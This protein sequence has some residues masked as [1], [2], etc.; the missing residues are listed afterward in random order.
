MSDACYVARYAYLN[1]R[2]I[3]G[4]YNRNIYTYGS[5]EYV[6]TNKKT[7]EVYPYKGTTTTYKKNEITDFIKDLKSKLRPRDYEYYKMKNS[8]LLLTSTVIQGT[9]NT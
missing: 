6:V 1:A 2:R 5:F 9:L 8:T 3:F 4:N 7:E